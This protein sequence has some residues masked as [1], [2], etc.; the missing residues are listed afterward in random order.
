[1]RTPVINRLKQSKPPPPI[2]ATPTDEN[3]RRLYR[4]AQADFH[5]LIGP[6]LAAQGKSAAWLEVAA[7]IVE[8]LAGLKE[9]SREAAAQGA[10]L[11]ALLRVANNRA[12]IAL[13]SKG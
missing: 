5:A 3:F 11:R 9:T 2:A 13:K 8:T 4:Q 12:V 10:L 1:M 6:Q 7:L